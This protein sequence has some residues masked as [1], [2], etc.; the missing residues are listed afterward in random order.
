M[1]KLTESDKRYLDDILGMSSGYVLD[2]VNRT[3]KIF[4]QNFDIDIYSE[5]YK[6]YGESKGKRMSAFL[7]TEE[8]TIVTQ[9]LS[10]L[11]DLYEALCDT[12]ETRTKNENSLRKCRDIVSKLSG[13]E[14]KSSDSEESKYLKQEFSTVNLDKLRVEQTLIPILKSRF[15]EATRAFE[16][17]AYLAVIF[18]CGSTLEGVLLG[19]A[20]NSPKIFRGSKYAQKNN[21]GQIE[22]FNK[23]TLN[24]L[25]NVATDVG[26]LKL[27]V[28]MFSHALREF[29]NYIHPYAELKSEFSPDEHTAKLCLQALKAAIASLVG[30][31]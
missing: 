4:F 8:N 6:I 24:N 21:K 3:F 22:D 23:W 2:F 30:E 26:L 17:K 11:L 27:D 5:K 13:E 16:A 31:R 29:R 20:Y 1:N 19:V 12:S 25:I 28:K 10:A 15:E 9:V 18:M 14:D 7:D